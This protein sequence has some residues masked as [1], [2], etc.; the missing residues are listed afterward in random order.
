M[1]WKGPLKQLKQTCEQNPGFDDA[2]KLKKEIEKIICFSA[3]AQSTKLTIARS[4]KT[5]A[6]SI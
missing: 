2:G 1:P 6:V 3:G 4:S 5:S